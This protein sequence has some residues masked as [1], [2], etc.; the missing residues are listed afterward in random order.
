MVVNLLYNT[1]HTA[2]MCLC[3]VDT[4]KERNCRNQIQ[5]LFRPYSSMIEKFKTDLDQFIIVHI[6]S[7]N[8]FWDVLTWE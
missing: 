4:F 8:R 3:L 5:L 1:Y 7:L 6:L 2:D